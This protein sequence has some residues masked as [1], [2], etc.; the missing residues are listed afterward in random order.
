MGK[1][2]A[3]APVRDSTVRVV[4]RLG[5]NEWQGV[6]RPQLVVEY[7]EPIETARML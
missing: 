2:D 3:V 4:Y 6:R 1:P 5:V 7:L